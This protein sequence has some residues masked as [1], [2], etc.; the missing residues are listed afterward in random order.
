VHLYY[1]KNK[2]FY[3]SQAKVVAS[4]ANDGWAT[5]QEANVKIKSEYKPWH[6]PTQQ[7]ILR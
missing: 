4:E 1:Y 7:Q 6:R 2:N 5:G 3:K